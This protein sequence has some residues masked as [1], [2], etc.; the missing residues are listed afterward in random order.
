MLK[1]EIAIKFVLLER[2]KNL[3]GEN[4]KLWDLIGQGNPLEKK[5]ELK[6]VSC[7][8]SIR[9]S[10]MAK[11]VVNRGSIGKFYKEMFPSGNKSKSSKEITVEIN[12]NP[13]NILENE[14][15]K[16]QTNE[17]KEQSW[18]IKKTEAEV[19]DNQTT[20]IEK[21]PRLNPG[22]NSERPKKKMSKIASCTRVRRRSRVDR[23]KSK[24]KKSI[25]NNFGPGTT[26]IVI[27]K[28]EEIDC[29][30]SSREIENFE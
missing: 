4:D 10:W 11:E 24:P 12:E 28:N 1:K 7:Q 21:V 9:S 2:C 8:V 15:P 25:L 20:E 5:I 13:E 30:Y 29:G 27:Q 18:N 22:M 3:K 6:E 19:V 23:N 14:Y 16:N 26:I 17:N